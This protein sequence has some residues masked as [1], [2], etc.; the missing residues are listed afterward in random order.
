ME[1][2]ETSGLL[3]TSNHG[4]DKIGFW[5]SVVFTILTTIGLS[6]VLIPYFMLLLGPIIFVIFIFMI[7]F[8]SN[9]VGIILKDTIANAVESNRHIHREEQ[10][11]EEEENLVRHTL[12]FL[13]LI[14]LNKNFSRLVQLTL[15]VLMVCVGIVVMLAASTLLNR[16][17]PMHL[18]YYNCIR[19][20]LLITYTITAPFILANNYKESRYLALGGLLSTFTALV[21]VLVISSMYIL[22]N[23]S[24]TRHVG[25]LSH[26]VT[27]IESFFTTFGLLGFLSPNSLLPGIIVQYEQPRKFGFSLISSFTIIFCVYVISAVVP[28]LAFRD[29][30]KPNL[31]ETLY[32]VY[33]GSVLVFGM[34]KVVQFLLAIHL[35]IG[36]P[37]VLLPFFTSI[38]SSLRLRN[39]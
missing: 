35:L 38:E 1:L 32:K 26:T 17:I 37:F 23:G 6:T 36:F 8:T 18:S 15:Y 10:N 14:A 21:I 24:G 9:F 11:E 2:G 20:W 30:L 16:I 19:V 27:H 3:S 39:G 34:L 13:A 33:S 28:Y 12:P 25:F 22:Q 31:L 7:L 5:W 29:Q 4:N